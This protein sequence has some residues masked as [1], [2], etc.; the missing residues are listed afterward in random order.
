MTVS[1]GQ[2]FTFTRGAQKGYR[3]ASGPAFRALVH[4]MDAVHRGTSEIGARNVSNWP[5][6]VGSLCGA[7]AVLDGQAD[8]DTG[9]R[10]DRGIVRRYDRDR[11]LRPLAFPLECR[12]SA[13]ESRN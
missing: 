10:L 3:L 11:P 1:L 9:H 7:R 4:S 5:D 8:S 13:R 2:A 12:P 6:N